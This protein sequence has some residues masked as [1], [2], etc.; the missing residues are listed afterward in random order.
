MIILALDLSTQSTGY[1]LFDTSKKSKKAKIRDFGVISIPISRDF[2]EKKY[3][4]KIELERLILKYRPDVILREEFVMNV[5]GQSN[6]KGIISMGKFH[7]DLEEFCWKYDIELKDIKISDIKLVL[8]LKS[9]IVVPRAL[10]KKEK[11]RLKKLKRE[12]KKRNTI[13][14][15]NDIFGMSLDYDV[16]GDE[17]CA[18]AISCIQVYLKFMKEGK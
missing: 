14:I 6:K 13:E 18:D 7:G 9:N 10:P 4:F 11:I 3:N 2:S 12:E 16:K 17:D 1:C 8:G 5:R 15:V